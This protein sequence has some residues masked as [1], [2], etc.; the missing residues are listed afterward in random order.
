MTPTTPERLALLSEELGAASRD[1]NES[2]A[3][4]EVIDGAKEDAADG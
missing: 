2:L 3:I 4:I 1:L